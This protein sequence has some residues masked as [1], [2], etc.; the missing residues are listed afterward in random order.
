MSPARRGDRA[1][2]PPVPPPRFRRRGWAAAVG[3]EHHRQEDQNSDDAAAAHGPA[4]TSPTTTAG[5]DAAQ[6]PTETAEATAHTAK[7]AASATLVVNLA[8]I[9][10]SVVAELH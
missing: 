9:E 7:P 2:P 5:E 3:E 8:G 10:P 6:H 4:P 1:A